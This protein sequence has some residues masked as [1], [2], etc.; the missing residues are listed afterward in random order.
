MGPEKELTIDMQLVKSYI[1]CLNFGDGSGVTAFMAEQQRIV[2]A[3]VQYCDGKIPPQEMARLLTT[4]EEQK[5]R[6]RLFSSLI[7]N[8][9]CIILP[10]HNPNLPLSQEDAQTILDRQKAFKG[11][12]YDKCRESPFDKVISLRSL[13][14]T[15]G[16]SAKQISYLLGK[17]QISFGS[18]IFQFNIMEGGTENRHLIKK[19]IRSSVGKT[20]SGGMTL[21]RARIPGNIQ[22]IKDSRRMV[23]VDISPISS[24]TQELANVRSYKRLTI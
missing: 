12:Y 13:S 15:L 3:L 4:E 1:P 22:R 17:Y 20:R 23:A 21:Y 18:L 7:F 5:A 9:L 8:T 19:A 16:I 10:E 14:A 24:V 2:P 6:A 11:D